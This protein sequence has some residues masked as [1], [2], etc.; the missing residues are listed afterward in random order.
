MK[1]WIRKRLSERST[2]FAAMLVIAV[3]GVAGFDLTVEQQSQIQQL[4]MIGFAFV[5]SLTPDKPEA[6]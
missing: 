5:M 2:K 1:A 6:K 3:A 4:I